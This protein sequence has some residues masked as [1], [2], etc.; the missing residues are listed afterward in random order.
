MSKVMV[1]TDTVACIPADLAGKYNVKVVPAANIFYNGYEYIE[2]ITLDATEAYQL[3]KKDPDRFVTSAITPSYRFEEYLKFSSESANIFFV[4][5]SSALSAG[6]KT[7][8]LAIDLL[9]EKSP[10]TMIRVFDSKTVGGAQGLIAL[11]AAKAAAKGMDLDDITSIAE[12]ARTQ[13]YGVMMLD[14][15]RY[16]YRTGRMSK[17]GAR[18]ASMF[19]I[20]P[21]NR[22]TE[23]GRVEM[24]D[25]TRNRDDGLE[26]LIQLI[27]D[28]AKTDTLHFIVSHSDALETANQF[29]DMLKQKFNCLSLIIS[30]YSPVMG[31]G[32]GPGAIFV[33]FQPEIDLSN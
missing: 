24:V 13:T 8:Q 31:Y 18:I 26:I 32:A 27:Q 6:S 5:L 21:I 22:I 15:L 25:R 17:M 30:D 7:A 19:N 10:K 2:G 11:V 3:I 28:Y 1:M 29:A 23:E 14:T 9:K 12:K 20:R 4:T 16:V 33:G